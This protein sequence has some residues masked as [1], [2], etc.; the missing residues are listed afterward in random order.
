MG[1]ETI[2]TPMTDSALRYLADERGDITAVLVPID[3]WR[4]LSSEAETNHLLRSPVMRERLVAAMGR[5][6]GASLREAMD[7]A[8]VT[9]AEVDEAE[10]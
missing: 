2:P 1:P 9:D 7:Q 5:H 10:A 6:G 3:T 4:E 8:G